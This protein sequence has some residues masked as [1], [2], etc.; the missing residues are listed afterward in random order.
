[1][2]TRFRVAL[3]LGVLV[4]TVTAFAQAPSKDISQSGNVFAEVCSVV[5]KHEH[6]TET[7]VS[8]A[9][10]CAGFMLGIRE[11]AGLAF[12]AMKSIDPSFSYLT[13]SMEDF[14]V[15]IPTEVTNG[16]LIRVALKFIHEN[17]DKAHLPTAALTLLA[18]LQA[19][20]CEKPAQKP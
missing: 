2:N 12:T 1:M 8:D 3:V 11:G 20:P 9:A 18:D 16:Q 15:C 6:L 10:Y 14:R 19:F 5:D 17:P 4:L 7:D 13:G